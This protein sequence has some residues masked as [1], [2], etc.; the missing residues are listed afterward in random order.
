MLLKKQ[1]AVP[2]QKSLLVTAIFNTM[3]ALFITA[4]EL[5]GSWAINFIFSQ[6]IGLSICVSVHA[7][8][9]L[10]HSTS[11]L[12]QTVFTAAAILV[13]TA[14]GAALAILIS[15]ENPQIFL[16]KN[17]FFIQVL[18]LGLLF[19]SVGTY[20]FTSKARIAAGE[21]QIKAEQ[22]Q[23]LTSDKKAAEAHLKQLQAQIEPHFLFNTLSNILSLL[24]TDVEKGKTMLEDF[25][26]YLRT[27]LARI[28][29]GNSR[30]DTEVKLVRSYLNLYKVRMGDRMRF[31]VDISEQ[32]AQAPFP[33]M[34]L[35]P[36]VENAVKHGLETKIDGGDISIGARIVGNTLRLEVTDTGLGLTAD[37]GTGMGLANIRERLQSVYGSNARLLLEEN[38]PTGVKAVIEVPYVADQRHHRG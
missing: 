27:A 21:A 6:C 22:I 29:D 5:G 28:R 4:M 11:P 16:E 19:G 23:R 20:F 25:V 30:V 34:L 26:Q 8:Y 10:A 38:Q 18:L 15:G 35:Q 24:E 9:R 7:T 14:A 36:L 32:A 13:A 17:R 31:T 33:P 3:I 37:K 12:L 2:L 1:T